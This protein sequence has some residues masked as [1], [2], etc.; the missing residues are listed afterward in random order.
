MS[1]PGLLVAARYRLRQLIGEGGMGRVWLGHDEMLQRDI[2]VKEIAPPRSPWSTLDDLCHSLVNEA[3]AA[4]QLTNPHVVPIY[5]L[6]QWGGRPWIVMEYVPSRSLR[7]LINA[8]GGLAPRYVATVGLALLDGL[9]SAHRQGIL[10]RDVTPRNVLIG[11]D[12]RI[13]LTDFGLASWRAARPGVDREFC[14]TVGYVAPE[15]AAFGVSSPAGDLWSLGATLYAAVEGQ[16]P[17]VQT[18]LADHPGALPPGVLE[19][20]GHAGPLEPVLRGLLACDPRARLCPLFI[21]RLLVQVAGPAVDGNTYRR[22]RPALRPAKFRCD[23]GRAM[24]QPRLAR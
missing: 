6:V 13:L 11:H 2:A 3:R 19:S 10:H 21:R 20:P 1:E 15:R 5:D 8:H 12:G 14:G 17:L 24:V 22:P 16:P 9:T 18:F 4:A 23:V 7:D